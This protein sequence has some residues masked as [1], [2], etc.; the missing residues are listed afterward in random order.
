M[1]LVRR[2][3]A[4]ASAGWQMKKAFFVYVVPWRKIITSAGTCS[5][6]QTQEERDNA[7]ACCPG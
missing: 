4:G 7:V 2:A 3:E 1:Y 6:G 5:A